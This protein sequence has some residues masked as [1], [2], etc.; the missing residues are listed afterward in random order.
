MATQ[1]QQKQQ[2]QVQRQRQ[3]HEQIL[4][5]KY[6]SKVL[7]DGHLALPPEKAKAMKLKKGDKISIILTKGESIVDKCFGMWAGR[8]DFE[9]GVK[10]ESKVRAGWVSREKRE[11]SGK[12]RR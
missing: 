11:V 7:P 3:S 5:T 6:E 10:Y 4:S 9:S 1:V 12:V 2:Q 8:R